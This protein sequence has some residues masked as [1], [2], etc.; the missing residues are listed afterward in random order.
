LKVTSNTGGTRLAVSL[1]LADTGKTIEALNRLDS[2]VSLAEV[3]LDLMS[4]F[5]LP[6]LINESPIPLI[7]TCRPLREDGR[8][9]GTEAERMEIILEAI[10]LGCAYVDV[11][12]DCLSALSKRSRS[13]TKV[14]ASRHWA[15]FMPSSLVLVYNE[16]RE[17]ADVVKLAGMARDH[18]DVL[19]I[20]E[21]MSSASTPVI[22]IAMG[23]RGKI[24]R[25][26]APCFQHCFLTY[27]ALDDASVTAPGQLDIDEMINVYRLHEVGSQTPIHLFLRANAKSAA[28]AGVMNKNTKEKLHLSLVVTRP[29]AAKIARGILSYLPACALTADWELR[30]VLDDLPVIYG[31]YD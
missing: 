2:A 10:D 7:I 26:L 25:L 17:Q 9:Q 14:I 21:L 19:P 18:V 27:G 6:R 22:T 24:T 20:F 3:R 23:E 15:N 8:F 16:L 29:E 13:P 5:D 4:S 11:E 12:W 30:S 31:N 1:A 28:A